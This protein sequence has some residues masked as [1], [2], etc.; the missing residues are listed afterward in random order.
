M[1]LGVLFYICVWLQ[2]CDDWK[3]VA[4]VIDRFLLYV[5]LGTTVTGTISIIVDAPHIF[6]LVDQ[7]EIIDQLMKN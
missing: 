5:F 4:S 3:F 2:V 6:D 7:K 1:P